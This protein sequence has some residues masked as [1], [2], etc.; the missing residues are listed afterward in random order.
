MSTD[1]GSTVE[2]AIGGMTCASC[3]ARIGKKLNKMPGVE[4]SVNYATEHAT[5]TIHDDTITPHDL[6][7]RVEALGYSAAL[8]A[9]REEEPGSDGEG[10][11]DPVLVQLRTPLALSAMLARK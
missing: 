10:D 3:A 8:P 9:V 6:I 2:L 1:N 7:A 5:V 4:A 11:A